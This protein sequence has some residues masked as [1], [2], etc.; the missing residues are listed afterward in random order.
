M[1]N[2]DEFDK[3]NEKKKKMHLRSHRPHFFRGEI[4]WAQIG[5]NISSEV[6]GKGEDYL[7]PIVVI[8]KVYGNACLAI[9]LTS[10]IRNGNY[11]VS[12]RDNKGQL[13]CALLPQIRYLD[14]KRLKYQQSTVDDKDLIRIVN[15]FS[16]LIKK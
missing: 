6:A 12:F 13:Q 14:G 5:Q 16:S 11:Y 1:L 15:S 2:I 3:W 10:K 8:Q 7:R 4:W 9:P